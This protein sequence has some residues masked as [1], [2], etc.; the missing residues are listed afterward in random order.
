MATFEPN[1][2]IVTKTPSILVDAGLPPGEYRFQLVVQ[3][4]EGRRSLA[5]EQVVRIVAGDV[6]E[7]DSARVLDS[8][9]LPAPAPARKRQPAPPKPT[10]PPIEKRRRKQK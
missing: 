9:P 8:P 5:D 6:R 4:D 1:K 3:D 10:P 7:I 2:P